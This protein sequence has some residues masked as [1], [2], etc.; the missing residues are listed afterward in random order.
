M[1]LV[2]INQP[3]TAPSVAVRR[4][5]DYLQAHDVAAL[6]DASHAIAGE[7]FF[8]NIFRYRTAD[9]HER[10][11]EAHRDY[12]DVHWVLDG[13]EI[14]QQAFL[15]ACRV[16]DYH[17]ERDY[18]AIEEADVRTRLLLTS[19]HLAV[20]YPEDAHQTGVAD[21][22]PETIRKAVFKLRVA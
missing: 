13:A 16:G 21:G 19:G 7:D 20:F 10:I 9:A 22:M 3:I 17:A 11:W 15:A 18:L 6:D 5:L 2:A 8:V 14:V 12:I 1:E 4:V